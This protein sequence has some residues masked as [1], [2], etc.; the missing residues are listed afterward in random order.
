MHQ[1]PQLDNHVLQ[2]IQNGFTFVTVLNE[3]EPVTS[4][5]LLNIRLE[6]NNST[7]IWSKPA[8]DITN[9]WINQPVTA[10]GLS[11]PS[12]KIETIIPLGTNLKSEFSNN[13]TEHTKKE[14]EVTLSTE[15]VNTFKIKNLIDQLI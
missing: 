2:A 8:W 10:S 12:E 13:P 15:E 9:T 11:K 7:L 3:Q 5:C 6:P 1:N 4:T 14:T